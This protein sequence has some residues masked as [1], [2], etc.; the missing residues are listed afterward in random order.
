MLCK[1]YIKK[2]LNKI[3]SIL[4]NKVFEKIQRTILN[5]MLLKYIISSCI[6]IHQEM[7]ITNYFVI[8]FQKKLK[9]QARFETNE[10]KNLGIN[11]ICERNV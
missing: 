1:E 2:I 10:R 3:F 7:S 8:I 11:K 4:R 5:H 9:Y 6:E